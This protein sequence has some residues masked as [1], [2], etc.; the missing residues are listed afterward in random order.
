MYY[1][2]LTH[3]ARNE[4]AEAQDICEKILESSPAFRP[5]LE[6]L[7]KHCFIREKN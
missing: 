2:A 6:I 3:M 1:K 7:G 5:A 4:I